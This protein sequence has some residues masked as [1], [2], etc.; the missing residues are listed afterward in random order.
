MKQTVHQEL[1]KC[2]SVNLASAP[3]YRAQQWAAESLKACSVSEPLVRT[4][5][6]NR[7]LLYYPVGDVLCGTLGKKM[8]IDGAKNAH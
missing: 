6:R 3:R 1:E 7:K 8:N 2:K 4:C 5:N